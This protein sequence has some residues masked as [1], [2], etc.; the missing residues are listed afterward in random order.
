MSRKISPKEFQDVLLFCK[1]KGVDFLDL[2]IEV[3]DHLCNSIE[4]L[5][6][7]DTNISFQN[8][9]LTSYKKF[10][11]YGFT[12]VMEEHTNQML[13][14]YLRKLIS[15]MK[16]MITLKNLLIL[17]LFTWALFQLSYLFEWARIMGVVLALGLVLLGPTVLL[18]QHFKNKNILGKE[19][20]LL[21]SSHFQVL[22]LFNYFLFLALKPFTW[23]KIN[24]PSFSYLL[25]GFCVFLIVYYAAS[26]KIQS[27]IKI[28]LI[29]LKLKLS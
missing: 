8:A 11:I 17:I 19:K 1:K 29:H 6:N 13:S 5:W 22:Y 27:Q 28:E 4:Q 12:D 14:G 21:L 23:D 9:L 2:R 20:T 7:K 16:A 26:F 25:T 3:A 24:E 18:F 15:T 10:G